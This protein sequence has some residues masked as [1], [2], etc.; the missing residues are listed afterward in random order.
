MFTSAAKNSTGEAFFRWRPILCHASL[1]GSHQTLL[2]SL[3][4]ILKSLKHRLVNITTGDE[5]SNNFAV[6]IPL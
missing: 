2:L 6:R 4:V 5:P 3:H 1:I